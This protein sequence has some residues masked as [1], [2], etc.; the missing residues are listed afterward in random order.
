MRELILSNMIKNLI[1]LHLSLVKGV[2]PAHINRILETISVD[3]LSDL[4]AWSSSDFV[5]R[6]GLSIQTSLDLVAGLDDTQMLDQE[7]S[8]LEKENVHVLSLFDDVYPA[9]LRAIHMP[10]VVLYYKGQA[11]QDSVPAIAFV[12]ARA[13]TPYGK[14]IVDALVP[15]LAQQ[16]WNIVSGGAIGVDSYSHQAAV[17]AGGKTT[18]VLGSGLMHLYPKQNKRLFSDVLAT[19][20]TLLSPFSMRVE[21]LPGHFPARN[22]IIAGLSKA[23]VVVQAAQ[24]SGSLI[25]AS[26]ALEQGRDVF[27]VPGHFDDPMSVGCHALFKQGAHIATSAQDIMLECGHDIQ[28]NNVQASTEQ[29]IQT[30]ITMGTANSVESDPLLFLCKY[31]ISIDELEQKTNLSLLELQTKLFDLQLEGKV[32]Q[33]FMGMWQTQ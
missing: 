18:V 2:G 25:T 17:Q 12:G 32:I 7:C 24:K 6:C 33:N 4:Y 26:F 29:F 5:N 21:A 15:P 19:G 23:C 16:G 28:L 9:L 13:A 27:A 20:G 10:P 30:T 3:D 14:K 11:L 31:P 8:S 22:R 1:I